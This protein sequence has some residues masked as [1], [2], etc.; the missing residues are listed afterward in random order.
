MPFA[1]GTTVPVART[2]GEIEALAEKHGAK[3]FASGWSSDELAAI[4]FVCYG[5]LIRFMLP[6]PT[7]DETRAELKKGQFYRYRAIPDGVLTKHYEAELRR[8][9]RCLLLAMKAKFEVVET[10]IE[11]FEQAFLANIV[12]ADNM[13]VWETIAAEQ[14]GV[15]L[16]NA[17]PET[18]PPR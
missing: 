15:R 10:K 16:L 6:L 3:R 13:T 4:S 12:T 14:S 5:R 11:T 2:R 17:V 9:W 8:R 7:R 18:E 1:E